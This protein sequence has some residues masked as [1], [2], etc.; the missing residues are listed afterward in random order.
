MK[1]FLNRESDCFAY[2]CE[3]F[4][5]LSIEKL[6][7]SSFDGPTDTTFNAGQIF[8]T[9]HDNPGK[10]VWR[11]FTAVFE[12]FLKFESSK[13]HDLLKQL[14]NSYEQ[15]GCNM[16]VKVHSPQS[17]VNYFPDNFEAMIEEQGESFHQ[18]IKT[19]EKRYQGARVPV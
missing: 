7:A 17:H 15:L 14:L 9:Y 18:D 2:L 13:Y 16:S 12:N 19:M 11:S 10:N 4:P 8:S 3:K 5:A 1:P 6:K